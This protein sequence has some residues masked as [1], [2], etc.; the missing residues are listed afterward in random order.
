MQSF[1]DIAR[2]DPQILKK[3]KLDIKLVCELTFVVISK[4]VH[5]YGFSFTE[6]EYFGGNLSHIMCFPGL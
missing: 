2:E 3:G 5:Y 6:R 4:D 1:K